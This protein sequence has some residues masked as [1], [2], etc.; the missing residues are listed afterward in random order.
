M[1]H[2]PEPGVSA[3]ASLASSV[4][5]AEAERRAE[6]DA[7]R[8]R[9]VFADDLLPGVGEEEMSLADGLLVGGRATFV[10]LM[11]LT[12]ADELESAALSVLA[13][14]IRDTFG[15]SDGTIVFMTAAVGG[16]IVLGGLPLGW[17]ADR[18]RRGRLIGSAGLFFTAMTCLSGLAV[19]AFMLFWTRAGVGLG[20]ASNISVNGSLLADTYPIGVR[21]RLNAVSY[22]IARVVGS[23]SPL[24]VG[25]IAALAG[26][27]EGW[28]WAF[29]VLGLPTGLVAVAALRLPEPVRGQ[30]E[31][32]EVL[33]EVVEDAQPAPISLEAGWARLMEIRTLRTAIMAFAAL[34]FGLFTVP[35]LG[36]LYT[37]DRFGLSAL[38][39]GLVETV[40]GVAL[41]AV[42]PFLGARFDRLYRADPSRALA[43]VGYLVIPVAVLTPLRFFM[44]NAWLFALMGIPPLILQSAA[45]VMIGP[46]VQALVPYR[47][48]GLGSALS[49][50]YIF[51]I[52]AVGGG[53]VSFLLLGSMSPRATVITIVIPST[54]VGGWMMVRSAS[55]IRGDLSMI[56]DDL[57]TELDDHQRQMA[58]PANV[59]AL[60][61][62]DIDFSYGPVQILF[63]IDF[64]VARGECLALLGTNGAGKST[65]LRVVAGLGTPS[66]GGIRLHGRNITYASPEQRIAAGIQ[67]LPGGRGVFPS[68]TVGDNL[69]VGAFTLR[70]DPADRQRRIDRVKSLFPAL[71]EAWDRPAGTLSGGQQQMLALARVLLRDTELLIIDE[72]SLG[73]APV[74][75]ADLLRVV[76]DLKA[77]GLTIIIVEQSLNL[78]L[79][80]ADRAVFLEK[81]RV[82]FDGPA[83]KLLQRDDLARA[84]FLGGE[85]PG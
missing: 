25:G 56:V 37:E 67:M 57:Q 40:G 42:L 11:L 26:G 2:D 31:K 12:A 55:F 32:L 18:M 28:R 9:P 8:T 64:I 52:G 47:L 45:F 80:L 29:L 17:L 62:H 13:P 51:F 61:V 60:Q 30:H 68:L 5:A 24:I 7:A 38:E 19:N 46:I 73:L 23:I 39:R 22:T 16:F 81:G 82:R 77:E 70:H 1:S 6:A 59:A 36:N 34:G 66:R 44:P 74:V 58:D 65:I 54:L 10:V 41:L 35:I 76:E 3:A 27:D 48:R 49:G 14:D 53:F 79:S 69:A 15:V 71:A 43:L 78:A 75:V 20:K 63:G 4:L 83:R 50:V 33:G 85:G 84:V 21:G 72:L